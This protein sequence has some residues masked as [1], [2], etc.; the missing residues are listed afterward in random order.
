MPAD[1]HF[2]RPKLLAYLSLLFLVICVGIGCR[3]QGWKRVDVRTMQSIMGEMAMAEASFSEQ[4]LSDSLR[5]IGY[6]ALLARHGL[7]LQDWD[8]SLVWYSTH[9]LENY[10]K[11]YEYAVN[12]LTSRQAPL[13]RKVDSLDS[14]QNR[15]W[16]WRAG[17]IDS[18]NL[19]PDSVSYYPAGQYVER[20]FAYTPD[21]SYEA[22]TRVTF[23]VRVLGLGVKGSKPLALRL[24]LHL[25]DSTHI[26]EQINLQ[27][28]GLHVITLELPSGK[29]MRTAYGSLRG[30]AP[31]LKGH[32]LA[33]DSFSFARTTLAISEP[34]PSTE[35]QEEP[36]IT[37]DTDDL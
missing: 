13:K 20:S 8:S 14:V 6:E 37:D 31:S 4:G 33:V 24:Q 30:F 21:Q 35:E 7:T 18:V 12:D 26:S 2:M 28:S 27:H 9:E 34:T 25:A 36:L 5:I 23:A 15:L 22:N 32:F 16:R 10:T 19:L 17:D 3:S 1:V 11:I 29:R